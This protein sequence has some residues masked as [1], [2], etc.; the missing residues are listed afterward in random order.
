MDT[1]ISENQE[2]SKKN[3]QNSS[4]DD[5][6]IFKKRAEAVEESYDEK[7]I[8][9]VDLLNLSIQKGASDIHLAEG[10]PIY[11]RIGGR[12]QALEGIKQLSRKQAEN[13][14][15]NMLTPE[16]VDTLLKTKDFDCAYQHPSGE[17]FRVNA[18]FKRKNLSMVTRM[19]PRNIKTMEDL[20]LP[21]IC[22]KFVKARQGLVLV[23]GPTGSGKSTSLAAM[24]EW[25]NVNLDHHIITIED[26]VE[27]IFDSKR[28]MFSQ[29]E[30]K[31]DTMS[32]ANALRS[33]LR[34]DPD[35]VVI[36]EMR[37][38]ETIGAA[39]TICETGH[40]VF[41]TLH[42]SGA[43][44]TISRLV[45][46]FPPIQQ[47]QVRV[48][49]AESLVGVVSQRLVPKIGGGRVAVFET[50]FNTPAFANMIRTGDSNQLNNAIQTGGKLGMISMQK[51]AMS[52]I[53]R[54]VVA[55]E[56]LDWLVEDD[57]S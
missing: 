36:G 33:V 19:I 2:I 6:Q 46:A 42:T 11:F 56:D 22:M 29:R 43:P 30:L 10:N 23:T 57:E 55:R 28:S 25:M 45:G 14:I 18:F 1:P 34:Q 50:F 4:T 24:L 20:N 27:F 5:V 7:E 32:M 8:N 3:E 26:P 44:Q 17:T 31:T 21:P 53:D 9:H 37:D 51:S 35:V 54:G 38:P 48:R 40:L 39:L 15:F 49:V 13:I 16:Q 47:D 52:L 12:L 41:G